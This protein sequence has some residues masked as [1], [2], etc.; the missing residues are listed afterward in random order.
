[1]TPCNMGLT[2]F[3]P[4]SR[5]NFPKLRSHDVSEDPV[6]KP[7]WLHSKTIR[8]RSAQ[9]RTFLTEVRTFS[10]ARKSG[11]MKEAFELPPLPTKKAENPVLGSSRLSKDGRRVAEALAVAAGLKPLSSGSQS[12]TLFIQTAILF[13]M[14]HIRLSFS[15]NRNLGL[16]TATFRLRC[17]PR[18]ANA[19]APVGDH[20]GA[21][22]SPLY[23]HTG[24][25]GSQEGLF[26]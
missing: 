12:P 11:P 18:P 3:P 14:D 24:P 5:S 20:F 2:P 4:P 21:T 17:S 1:M 25:N 26:I 7:W 10:L 13:S 9:Q 23:P 19:D 6:N 16:T 8:P 22:I 15:H